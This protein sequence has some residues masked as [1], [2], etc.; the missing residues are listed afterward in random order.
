MDTGVRFHAEEVFFPEKILVLIE[1]TIFFVFE[2]ELH[3]NF[4]FF[5]PVQSLIFFQVFYK[6][7]FLL[8]IFFAETM[9]GCEKAVFFTKNFGISCCCI[10]QDSLTLIELYCV[11][12]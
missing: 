11:I 8:S 12:L 6:Y 2:M 3:E 4:Y 5:E 7:N 1:K 10:Q 9:L